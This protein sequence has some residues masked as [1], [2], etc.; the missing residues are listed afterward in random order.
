MDLRGSIFCEVRE[1]A[2]EPLC[3]FYAAAL[4]RLM[5]LFDLEVEVGI[6][7]CRAT[8]SGQCLMNVTIRA[9]EAASV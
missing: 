8:G 2:Q 6:T 7:S 3:E 9:A 5:A 4:R 1:R